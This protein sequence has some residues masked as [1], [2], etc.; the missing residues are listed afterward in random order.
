VLKGYL[1]S[2]GKFSTSPSATPRSASPTGVQSSS[3][4]RRFAKG[5][6]TAIV[7]TVSGDANVHFFRELA[8]Q[9]ITAERIPVMSLSINEA[10]LPALMRSK[11][12]GH[13]VAWNYLHAFETPENRAFITE[14]RQFT[15]RPDAVTNDPMEATWIGFHLWTAAVEAAGTTD[16]DKVRAELGGR[17]VAAPSGFTVQIDPSPVQAGD[18][19]PYRGIVP[20]SS[21][22]GWCRRIR[23][24][25]GSRAH[26][27]C[28]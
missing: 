23:G 12:S 13:F 7:A 22:R 8:N 28:N 17:R 18:D 24:V 4:I 3:D 16:V 10:E 21:P 27:P 25:P 6:R 15:G 11:V 2:H 5:G 9:G 20:V 19:R 14:W 1:A 26:R